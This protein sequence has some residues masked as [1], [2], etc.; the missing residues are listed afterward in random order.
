ML[1][2]EQ[3]AGLVGGCFGDVLRVAVSQV[4]GKDV[5]DVRSAV[6][7][8]ADIGH[9]AGPAAVPVGRAAADGNVGHAG[10]G[11]R[12]DRRH[13]DVEGGVVLRDAGPDLL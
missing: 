4:G 9:A 5:A 11:A 1:Q 8:A 2:A 12:I 3:V 7:K 6:V 10:R 13:V